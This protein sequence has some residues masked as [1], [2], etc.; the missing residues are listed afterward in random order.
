MNQSVLDFL[1]DRQATSLS[2]LCEFLRIPSVSADS[3][4]APQMQRCAAWVEAA[5]RDAGLEARIYPTDG[6]P[7][8]FG[9]RLVDPSLPTVLVYGHYDVQPPDPLN[10]WTTP[11]F[12]PTVRDGKL[13]ARGATD[14]KGQ[15]FT[16]LKALQ[17]WMEIAG[18]LPLN[19]K[20]LIEGEEECGGLHLEQ[21]LESH[22][23]L[24]RADV[25]VISDT[26]QYGNGIPAITCGLRGIVAAE[27]RLRGPGKD[28]HSGI[29]GGSIANPVN[30]LTRMC[31]ALIAADGRVQIPGFYDDVIELS[32]EE[33]TGYAALPFSEEDF[34]RETGSGAVFGETGWSTLE[35]RTARPTCDINGIVGGYTGEGPKT[36]IPSRAMAKITCRLVPAMK[37]SQILD[38]LESFLKSLCP[39][40]IE[41]EF[42][43][44]HGCEA[45][46][47]DPTSE[48]LTA[49]KKAI[50]T[51][52]GQPPVLFREGGS[53]PVVLSF[54]QILGLD[55]LL[56]GWGRNSDNLHSPDE[57]IHLEDFHRGTLAS[58]C[59]WD[60]LSRVGR[61]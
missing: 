53:I 3:A 29:Y 4:F 17:A 18:E 11:A 42:R 14:D 33:R 5:M 7:I 8:V 31:G 40:G 55:T 57:H 2:E 19:V 1:K 41:F 48:W 6:H 32:V 37:P 59:L 61:R 35:R 23:E 60:E 58:A 49:A 20:V 9:E 26:S 45:F 22:R 39:P 10:L 51:A 54:K 43:R 47:F 30:A 56:L 13:F 21:F 28:L 36:I 24:L 50:E 25:A 38:S 46:V 34:L 12:E 52:F 15:L 27:V 16:H 44:F